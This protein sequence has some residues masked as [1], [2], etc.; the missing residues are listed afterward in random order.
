MITY[1]LVHDVAPLAEGET[2]YRVRHGDAPDAQSI[3]LRHLPPRSVS[4]DTPRRAVLYLNGARLPSAVTIALRLDGWSWR[5]DLAAQGWDVWGM[6]YIGYG[7]SDW[8]P[9]MRQPR[10]ANPPLGRA[11]PASEQV[12]TAINFI[13]Q[14]SG[15]RQLSLIAH[16]WGTNIGALVAIK[17]PDL[18]EHLAMFGP[19]THRRPVA[20][21]SAG[22]APFVPA[23]NV[24]T[25]DEWTQKTLV[26]DVPE[27]APP[28]IQPHLLQTW[29]EEFL[30]C[31]PHAHDHVP[32]GVQMPW[33]AMADVLELWGGG[34]IYD[35]ARITVPTIIVRGEWDSYS[36][37]VDARWI[38]DNLTNAPRKRDVKIGNA[39]HFMFYEET[40]FDLYQEVATFLGG[41]PLRT[42][43]SHR[44][45]E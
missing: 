13:L 36:T 34:K 35:P 10:D 41:V 7:H 39:T 1:A 23:W 20:A 38:M 22:A 24:T 26:A 3:F 32:A 11:R 31:D 33:G 45:H 42:S 28:A 16:S 44:S 18:I 17:N 8:F 37:D 43:H 15:L 9:E 40:R 6:D 5:D 27:G 30:K 4:T 2:L 21:A 12:E 29:R 25:A 19:V 14:Q